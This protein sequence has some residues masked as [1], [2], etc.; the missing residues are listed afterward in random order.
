MAYSENIYNDAVAKAKE[1]CECYNDRSKKRSELKAMR[2]AAMTAMASF[3]LE[4]SKETYRAWAE[5]GHPVETAIRERYIAGAKTIQFKENDETGDMSYKVKDTNYDVNLP[6]MHH[7]IGA[8]A[9]AS[10]DWFQRVEKF[11]QL[12]IIKLSK[13][14]DN[15]DA[16]A[17][18]INEL[19]KTFDFPQDVNPMDDGNIARALQY[20]YDGIIYI[21]KDGENLIH[22]TEEVVD[23]NPVCS[24]WV[25][26]RESMT[27][28]DD[29][30]DGLIN[31]V[32]T[33]KFTHIILRTLH[34]VI[35]NLK[36]TLT[37]DEYEPVFDFTEADDAAED[38]EQ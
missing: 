14:F 29:K 24:Q 2:K 9:F 15:R 4:L 38:D 7:T 1:Y 3:N 16:F 37:E 36:F 8:D 17:Y 25:Y 10:P 32:N 13:N 33:A 31:V 34:A 26:I 5:A 18:T 21:D 23:G 12:V 35:S 28:A 30:T 11:A 22:T 19:S 6:M 20:V 27:K